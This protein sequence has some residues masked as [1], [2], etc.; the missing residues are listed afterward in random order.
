MIR[1]SKARVEFIRKLWKR[2]ALDNFEERREKRLIAFCRKT[3]NVSNLQFLTKRD[4]DRVI[5]AMRDME[6]RRMSKYIRAEKILL[7]SLSLRERNML[8]KENPY[9]RERDKLIRTLNNRGV[10]L[11][12]LE[13]ISGLG[14]T[15]IWYITRGLKSSGRPY[16]NPR[17]RGQRRASP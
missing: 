8:R 17:A 2:V 10:S 7:Q 11:V 9:H 15:A 13:R 4:G 14:A 3:V 1:I 6:R 12:L 16:S 5:K